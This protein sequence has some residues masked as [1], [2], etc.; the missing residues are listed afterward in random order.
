MENNKNIAIIGGGIGGLTTALCLEHFGI[1]NYKVY[2]RAPEFK[3]VGA[4]ISLWPNALK[5]YKEIGLYD[6][7]TQHWGEIKEVHIR[8]AKGEFLSKSVPNYDYPAV[9]IH[10]AH[11]HKV[12]YDAIPKEKLVSDSKLIALKEQGDG[13][14]DLVFKDKGVQKASIVIGADG[15]HSKVRQYIINDGNPMDRG[16]T[17]WRGVTN[18]TEWKNGLGAEIWGKGTR[19]GIVPIKD[20]Q[21]GWWATANHNLVDNQKNTL[22]NIQN[23]FGHWYAP[24]P[25]L[26]SNTEHIITNTIADRLPKKQ[27]FKNN[28]VLM[29]DAAHPTTPNLGQGACMAIEGAYLLCKALNQNQSSEAF[30][31]YEDLH[32]TRT[33]NIVNQ[34]LKFGKIGQLENK[35]AVCAR[36]TMIKLLPKEKTNKAL[37]KFFD[38]DVTTLS[39]N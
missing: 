26:L 14:V 20:N 29:G 22:E 33:K 9:C 4:A 11:L 25:N 28:I 19:V 27:W 36:D 31:V 16:Y 15:I 1:T 18:T 37:D 39:F 10:R 32:F 23:L 21:L 24:I 38:H 2:E 8:N 12:L 17:I 6:T 34:S 30:K 5:V 35:I 3:E 13:S 7:L